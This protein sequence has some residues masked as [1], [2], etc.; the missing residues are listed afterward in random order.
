MDSGDDVSHTVPIYEGYALPHAILRLDLAG[1]DHTEYFLK[2]LTERRS[3]FT[4]SAVRKI[5]CDV[6]DKVCYIGADYDTELKS[7]GKEKITELPDGNIITVAPS[8]PVSR[9]FYSSHTVPTYESFTLHHAILCMTDRD[10]TEY[11]MKDLSKRGFSFCA[12]GEKEIVQYVIEIF[13]RGSREIVRDVQEK[14]STCFL[15]TTLSSNRPRTLTRSRP[16]CSQTETSSLSLRTF[17]LRECFFQPSV[18]GKEAGGVHDTS[19]RVD[20]CKELYVNVV[21][22]VGTTRFH[23]FLRTRRRNWR[24]WLQP[25]WRSSGCST[26]VKVL[27]KDLHISTQ[28]PEISDVLFCSRG[29]DPVDH[30]HRARC[31]ACW[32]WRFGLLL[33]GLE[34]RSYLR[35]PRRKHQHCHAEH[36]RCVEVLFQPSFISEEASGSTTPLSGA[37]W[38]ATFTSARSQRDCLFFILFILT[39]CADCLHRTVKKKT[40]RTMMTAQSRCWCRVFKK[41]VEWGGEVD[42]LDKNMESKKVVKPNVTTDFRE[43]G[44][45]NITR[46]RRR[47][48]QLRWHHGRGR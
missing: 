32:T 3:S 4:A 30:A 9:K 38:N 44:W 42:D 11:L 10:F 33:Y 5:A 40:S 21:L 23:G 22:S 6:K 31:P 35:A 28:F 15:I 17:P 37:T 41:E 18:I 45:A 2:N 43:V 39:L 20:I 48:A 46:R 29:Q 47:Y 12:T 7:T 25:R 26:R 8:V 27:G 13:S 19:C 14:F 1:R 16:T 34:D 24:R 36:F